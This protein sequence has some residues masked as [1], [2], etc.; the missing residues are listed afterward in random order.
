MNVRTA[1]VYIDGEF[2]GTTSDGRLCAKFILND[3]PGVKVGVLLYELIDK[4]VMRG[5]IIRAAGN[6]GWTGPMIITEVV[7]RGTSLTGM[8][9]SG[10]GLG[11]LLEPS[12]E[13]DA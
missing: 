11:E 5:K 4:R 10:F 12:T 9:A 6:M 3:V 2:V 8:G 1:R 7:V 13:L